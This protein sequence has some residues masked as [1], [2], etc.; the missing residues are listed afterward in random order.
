MGL[1]STCSTA[2]LLGSCAIRSTVVRGHR[3]QR[4]YCFVLWAEQEFR[5]DRLDLPVS[6]SLVEAMQAP[7][8]DW[9]GGVV[10]PGVEESASVEATDDD[11]RPRGA[12]HVEAL[13]VR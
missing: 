5:E 7:P 3:G 9:D 13:P 8:M 12:L 1:R 2:P 11:G 10:P 6:L 4:E